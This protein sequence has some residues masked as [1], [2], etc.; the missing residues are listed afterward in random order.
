MVGPR[1]E[2]WRDPGVIGPSRRSRSSHGGWGGEALRR[3]PCLQYKLIL[4]LQSRR[5]PTVPSTVVAVPT[6]GRPHPP[7]TPL[8]RA[9]YEPRIRWGRVAVRIRVRWYSVRYSS[10]TREYEIPRGNRTTGGQS[11]WSNSIIASTD[12][13]V[14]SRRPRVELRRLEDSGTRAS[15]NPPEDNPKPRTISPRRENVCRSRLDPSAPSLSFKVEEAGRSPRP[16]ERVG[17][18]ER[19]HSTRAG[20]RPAREQVARTSP[21]PCLPDAAR[22]APVAPTP[23]PCRHGTPMPAV[24][25]TGSARSPDTV[26]AR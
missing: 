14:V 4:I 22:P 19:P 10:L 26:S 21:Y 5:I 8:T 17:T 12:T 2:C 18:A 24:F 20:S 23:R 11:R 1:V 15:W 25:P 9:H 16:P 3:S 6:L 13:G 7:G